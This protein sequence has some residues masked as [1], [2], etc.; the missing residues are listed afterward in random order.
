MVTWRDESPLG[1][2]PPAHLHK[3][4]GCSGF[5]PNRFDGLGHYHNLMFAHTFGFSL[6][7][8]WVTGVSVC[9]HQI[10]PDFGGTE[11]TERSAG[12][13]A[14]TRLSGLLPVTRLLRGRDVSDG[15][16]TNTNTQ[17]AHTT[18]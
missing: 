8:P 14:G 5:A 2:R 16:S 13:A 17:C 4:C 1:S 3:V 10:V 9:P 11:T 12:R 18:A 7:C 6:P 15:E